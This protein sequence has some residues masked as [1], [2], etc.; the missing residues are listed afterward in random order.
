VLPQTASQTVLVIDADP[1]LSSALADALV[2]PSRDVIVCHDFESAKMVMEN[3]FIT[4]IITDAQLSDT[5]AYE[6]LHLLESVR[7]NLSAIPVVVTTTAHTSEDIRSAAERGGAS[8]VLQ[9]PIRVRDLESLIPPIVGEVGKVTLVPTLEDVLDRHLLRS[10]FQPIVWNDNP[11]YVVGFEA[12]TRLHTQSLFANP[13]LLFQYAERKERVVDLEVAAATNAILAGRDLIRLG[14]LSINIHAAVFTQA[15]RFTD[16]V[17]DAAADAR[18][19]L[20]RIVLEITEQAP[21]PNI[22][23]V[24]AVAGAMRNVGLRFAFDDLGLAYSH[25]I[26]IAA[27]RPSYLKISQHFGTGCEADEVKRKIVQNIDQLAQ[28]FSSE[29]VLEGIETAETAAFA[30]QLGIRFGQGFYY[31]RPAS[32]ETLLAKYAH[33]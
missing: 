10:V 6:G 18:I 26:A 13:E 27:V 17:I 29:I 20:E 23:T 1:A 3:H 21:L 12:L 7:R 11:Q 25:L 32:K 33:A 4:H 28:S 8:A 2:G 5:L 22:Y 31:A 24:E 15:D 9:K 16:A 14:I 30:R 19:P